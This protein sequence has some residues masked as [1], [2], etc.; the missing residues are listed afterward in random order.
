MDTVNTAVMGNSRA[1]YAGNTMERHGRSVIE[2]RNARG[3]TPGRA[4]A[5]GLLSLASFAAEA[6]DWS[7]TPR[8]NL[9]EAYT[10]NVTLAPEGQKR[11]EF[12]TQVRPGVTVSKSG[13]RLKLNAAYSLESLSYLRDSDRSNIKHQLNAD[14]NAEWLEDFFF[15]DVRT[16]ISQQN[17][18]LLGTSSADNVNIT[19]NRADV[20]TF[21]VSPYI[22]SRIGSHANYLLRYTYNTVNTD[23][24]GISD[25]ERDRIAAELT[26]ARAFNKLTWRLAYEKEHTNNS[27]FQDFSRERLTG[28]LGYLLSRKLSLVTAYGYENNSFLSTGVDPEGSLWNAGFIWTPSQRTRLEARVGRRYFGDTYILDFSQRSRHTT[29]SVSYNEDITTSQSQFSLQ[30]SADTANLL[31]GLFVSAIPDPIIRAQF[32]EDFIVQNGLPRV[33][34]EALNFLTNQAFLQKRL[35]AAVSINGVRNTLIFSV[36]NLNRDAQANVAD[37]A[38]NNDFLLSRNIK[39]YGAAALWNWRLTPHMNSSVSVSYTRNEFENT[40]RED[41]L[42][43]VRVGLRKQLEKKVNGSVDLRRVERDSSQE[44]GDYKENAVTLSLDM[45]F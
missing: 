10:D 11:S 44:G 1:A 28:Q 6:A 13:K 4:V 20:R 22:R 33:T 43:S 5:L 30:T 42:T 2:S 40:G 23:A 8:L 16:R 18:S 26:S 34:V 41:D 29:W 15:T 35:Q 37:L 19:G 31:D 24:V 12:V 45:T 14:A 38:G 27:N 25:A 17:I 9:R 21:L 39:Q 3:H 36:F 32:V 7:I